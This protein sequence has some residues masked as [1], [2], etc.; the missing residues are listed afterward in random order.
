MTGANLPLSATPESDRDGHLYSTRYAQSLVNR[1][2][3]RPLATLA[4]IASAQPGEAY[5]DRRRG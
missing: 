4:F 1:T 2:N 3:L 5:P